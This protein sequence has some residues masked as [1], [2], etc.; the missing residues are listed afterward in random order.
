VFYA[1]LNVFRTAGPRW[2]LVL[3]ALLILAATII[4]G[5]FER[6]LLG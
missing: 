5:G 4:V 6:G 3:V 2:L 1:M